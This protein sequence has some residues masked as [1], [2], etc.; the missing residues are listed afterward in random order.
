MTA[1]QEK[2]QGLLRKKLKEKG[3]KVTRQ[4]MVILE[5]LAE[6]RGMHMA[7]EDIFEM[8]Q[9]EHPEMGLAT[10]YRTLQLL[11]EI[12][13]VDRINLDD[14]CIRYEIGH[15]F[16]G[17]SKHSHHHLICRKCGRVIPFEDDLLDELEAHIE[18]AAGFRVM[19][20]ELKF[21]GQCRECSETSMQK[22]TT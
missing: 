16:E 15:I 4:R 5:I 19:D 7:A 1:E 17:D 9:K 12:Q 18:D 2:A 11:Y 20:H 22:V 21:Y 13:L 10:V 6:H 3:L 14:G 8:I